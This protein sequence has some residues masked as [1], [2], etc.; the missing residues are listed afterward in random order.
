MQELLKTNVQDFIAPSDWP[1]SSPDLN[2]LGYN[3]WVVKK[4]AW[5]TTA[6]QF[7]SNPENIS[8]NVEQFKKLWENIKSL[9][10]AEFAAEKRRLLKT[11]GRP[12]SDTNVEDDPELDSCGI[13]IEMYTYI[14]GII[15]TD[16]SR[17]TSFLKT[18]HYVSKVNKQ[19]RLAFA[20]E[21]VNK[22]QDFWNS[23]IIFSDSDGRTMVWKKPSEQLQSKNLCPTVTPVE[24]SV[25]VWGC[26]SADLENMVFVDGNMNWIQYFNILKEN[27]HDNAEK[28]NIK[29][30]NGD[31]CTRVCDLMTSYDININSQNYPAASHSPQTFSWLEYLAAAAA[32]GGGGRGEADLASRSCRN[33]SLSLL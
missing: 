3:L 24:G 19:K 10:K 31:A 33:H 20:K 1:A 18:K 17:E 28:L 22:P 14:C 8:R 15:N 26:M 25:F 23:V 7:N 4:A 12:A 30:A 2:S 29:L 21:H 9:R 11:G 13:N 27:L 6:S 5:E 16:N 32:E